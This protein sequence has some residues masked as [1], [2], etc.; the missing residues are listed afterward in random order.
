M[1]DDISDDSNKRISEGSKLKL[2]NKNITTV[3]NDS[4][5]SESEKDLDSQ[6]IKTK[7][8]KKEEKHDIGNESDIISSLNK[9]KNIY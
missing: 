5:V 3:K 7:K 4:S 9:V 1:S 2:E 6:N 8:K